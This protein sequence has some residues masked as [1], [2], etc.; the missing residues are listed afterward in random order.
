MQAQF[1]LEMFICQH[2]GTKGPRQLPR[3]RAGF[4]LT[5]RLDVGATRGHRWM[6]TRRAAGWRY[7]ERPGPFTPRHECPLR[8]LRC[9]L[10]GKASALRQVVFSPNQR[11]MDGLRGCPRPRGRAPRSRGG[12]QG[13]RARQEPERGRGARPPGG[14]TARARGA[15][16]GWGGAGR[17]GVQGW[18]GPRR[19]R[20]GE[21]TGVR[22]GG[23]GRGL[24]SPAPRRAG[25]RP[26]GRRARRA[27][28]QATWR[29]ARRS[30]APDAPLRPGGRRGRAGRGPAARR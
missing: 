17:E 9:Y 4:P 29:Q 16:R 10:G 1:N 11:G 20:F 28:S 21:P 14:S 25:T 15:A 8:S 24:R 5:D 23:S 6:G 18:A 3:F 22:G 26:I 12:W 27:R 7:T 19:R 30:A 13:L 2:S